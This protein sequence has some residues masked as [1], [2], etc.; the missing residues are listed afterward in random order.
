MERGEFG[1][2]KNGAFTK[3]SGDLPSMLGC[4]AQVTATAA[5][6]AERG[7]SYRISNWIALGGAELAALSQLAGVLAVSLAGAGIGGGM[8][9][10]FVVRATNAQQASF[11]LAVDAVNMHNDTAACSGS[12]PPVA[13]PRP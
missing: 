6:A 2:Y 5:A 7:S 11:A 12:A 8:Y 4:S 10:V 3:L 9:G 1:V 13:G